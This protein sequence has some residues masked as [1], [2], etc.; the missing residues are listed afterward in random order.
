MA[1]DLDISFE[2]FPAASEIG[3]ATLAKTVKTLAPLAPRFVSVTHGADG[4]DQNRTLQTIDRLMI[5]NPGLGLAGHLTART[6]S[7]GETLAAAEDYE[8]AGARWVVALRGDSDAGAGQP[9]AP[10]PHG[11]QSTPE[12]VAGLRQRTDMR[13]AV[14]GYPEPHPDSR[15]DAADIE[16]LKRKVDAGADAIITQFFFD[17]NDFYRFVERCRAKGIDVPIVPGIMPIANFERIARFSARCGARI[18][19]RIADRF[20]KADAR[21]AS[22]DLALAICAGQCDD[23]REQGVR[24]FHFYTLNRADLTLDVCRALGIDPRTPVDGERSDKEP[25]VRDE[26]VTA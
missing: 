19:A 12:L 2:V 21:G 4:S 23:L 3:E 20:A 10:H 5:D 8:A 11:F 15:G 14:A 6:G 13:I 25:A 26:A 16:H 18:P 22:R 17:N 7:K 1:H 24:A 9:F